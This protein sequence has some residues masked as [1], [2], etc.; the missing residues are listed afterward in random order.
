MA[1]SR[2]CLPSETFRFSP[3]PSPPNLTV[4]LSF[5][6]YTSSRGLAAAASTPGMGGRPQAAAARAAAAGAAMAPN[7]G[8]GGEGF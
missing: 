5:E 2:T 6:T 1:L 8:A 3:G 4:P 7:A